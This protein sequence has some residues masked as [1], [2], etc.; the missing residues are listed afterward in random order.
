MDELPIE[1]DFSLSMNRSASDYF[2]S[3]DTNTQNQI[4]EYVLNSKS[5]L[6]RKS[7]INESINALSN[8]STDFLFFI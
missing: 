7:R 6:E 3:L 2:S 4:K 8:S 1:F 5:D